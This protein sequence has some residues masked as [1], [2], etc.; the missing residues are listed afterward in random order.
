MARKSGKHTG[1]VTSHPPRQPSVTFRKLVE[2]IFRKCEQF[3]K[4]F[5][6]CDLIDQLHEAFDGG[7]GHIVSISSNPSNRLMEVEFA[8]FQEPRRPFFEVNFYT[9]RIFPYSLKTLTIGELK[10]HSRILQ[11]ITTW[12]KRNYPLS[13][14]RHCHQI[15]SRRMRCML[16]EG[17]FF[18]LPRN[19]RR[20]KAVNRSHQVL[21]LGLMHTILR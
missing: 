16:V 11:N 9:H 19:Q 4:L 3:F 8:P 1:S 10:K 17:P 12:I 14:L 15:L 13:P 5:R 18:A 6:S 7:T 20:R 2:Y 21:H